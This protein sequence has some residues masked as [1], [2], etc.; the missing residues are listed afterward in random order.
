[1]RRVPARLSRPLPNWLGCRRACCGSLDRASRRSR[2]ARDPY[3]YFRLEARELLD[4]F[5]TTILAL[6]RWDGSAGQPQRLL[7][8]A[9]TLKGAARVV[10]QPEIASHAHAI[11]DVLA[12]FRGETDHIPRDAV[13]QI[14]RHL[15]D[16]NLRVRALTPAEA[17]EPA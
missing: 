8:L 16:I 9:N 1:M 7:R 6:E 12:P 4:Q 11:E 3:R 2:M 10:Q 5:G 14:L 15:D 17:T 13:D